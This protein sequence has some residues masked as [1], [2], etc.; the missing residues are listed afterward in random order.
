M[1]DLKVIEDEPKTEKGRPPQAAMV[2]AFTKLQLR[3]RE[4]AEKAGD[5]HGRCPDYDEALIR[6]IRVTSRLRSR[7]PVVLDP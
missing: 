5:A 1:L 4:E 2:D 7:Y 6:T 3:H